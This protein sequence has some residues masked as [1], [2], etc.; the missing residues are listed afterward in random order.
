MK[1]RREGSLGCIV[2]PGSVLTSLLPLWEKVAVG[3]LRPPFFNRTPMLCIGYAKSAPDEGVRPIDRKRPLTRP[4]RLASRPPFSHKGRG[5]ECTASLACPLTN[6]RKPPHPEALVAPAAAG[7]GAILVD[8]FNR[9]SPTE[10]FQREIQRAPVAVL[11]IAI[12]LPVRKR[13]RDQ[14]HG[15]GRLKIPN[16][17]FDI[18]KRQM[19]ERVA[20]QDRVASV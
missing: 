17:A 20:A 4:R 15:A 6:L 16:G 1:E 12:G 11:A 8:Q 5:E 7:F 18:R 2:S 10:R 3:G 19:H 13:G 14:P 9:R